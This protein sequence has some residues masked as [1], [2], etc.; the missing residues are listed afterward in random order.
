MTKV[1]GTELLAAFWPTLLLLGASL[2]VMSIVNR[3]AESARLAVMAVS[4]TLLLRYF[5]WR[6][7]STLPPTGLTAD[8]A[9]GLIFLFVETIA[10]VAAILSMVFLSRSRDRTPERRTSHGWRHSPKSR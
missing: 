6:A 5:Y 4:V 2:M 8:F 10:L 3:R 9:A 7:T 1:G